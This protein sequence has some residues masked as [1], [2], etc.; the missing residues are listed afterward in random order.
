MFFPI[1]QNE[2][3]ASL[4]ANISNTKV[5][6]MKDQKLN[7]ISKTLENTSDNENEIYVIKM[8]NI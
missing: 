3:E 6:V 7:N 5:K 1:L 8:R 2:K 4:M